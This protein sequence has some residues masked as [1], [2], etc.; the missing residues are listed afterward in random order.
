MK[1]NTLYIGM[2]STKGKLIVYQSYISES[3]TA[4]DIQSYWS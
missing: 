2:I 3:D 4:E 1:G